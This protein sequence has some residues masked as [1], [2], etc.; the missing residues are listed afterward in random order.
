MF[1][2]D[3]YYFE[4]E[5][6]F[7]RENAH[8]FSKK[9]PNE[10]YALGLTKDSIDDPEISRLIESVCMLN[11]RIQKRLDDDYSEF[12]ESLL[13]VIYPDYLRSIPSFSII[14]V[15]INKDAN[16]KGFVPKGTLFELKDDNSNHCY[17]RTVHDLEVF[18]MVIKEL[19]TYTSPFDEVNYIPNNKAKNIIELVF[20]TTDKNLSFLDLDLKNLDILIKP[21]SNF[22]FKIYDEIRHNLVDIYVEISGNMYR[23]GSE[24]FSNNA[25]ELNDTIVPYSRNSFSGLNLMNEFF[26]YP[27][28][29]NKFRIDLTSVKDLLLGNTFKLKIFLKETRVEI[30]RILQKENFNLNCV[31]IVNIYEIFADPIQIDFLKDEYPIIISENGE[32]LSLYNVIS[33]IDSTEQSKNKI[34]ELY[35]ETYSNENSS[36]RWLVKYSEN[37][38]FVNGKIKIIDNNHNVALESNHT[39]LV[40][41]LVTDGYRITKINYARTELS[42][43]SAITIPGVVKLLRRPSIQINPKLDKASNWEM[44][45]HMTFN[46]QS[47]LGSENSTDKLKRLFKL[48][49]FNDNRLVQSFIESIKSIESTQ[50]V[51]PIRIMNK[52]CY[53]NGTKAVVTLDSHELKDGICIFAEFLNR[54]LA[55]FVNYNSFIKVSIILEGVDEEFISFPRNVGCKEVI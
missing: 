33:V 7:L 52:S 43:M 19:N 29:F 32:Q 53:V 41:V 18:P 27:D 22:S 30:F 49:N 23:L 2:S 11:A 21:E 1:N 44:L 3:L 28:V 55:N 46:F 4:E 38:G 34:P 25:F 13:N 54:F 12:T 47:L 24:S 6:S 48:Y 36:K 35:N 26:M 16:T 5:L 20:E 37:N 9:H 17:Y 45:A 14:Q 39:L 40:K 31:P 50:V 42:P 51:E 10:A 15:D 8:N